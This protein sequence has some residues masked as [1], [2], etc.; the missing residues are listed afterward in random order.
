MMYAQQ[1]D[2]SHVPDHELFNPERIFWPGKEAENAAWKAEIERRREAKRLEQENITKERAAKRTAIKSTIPYGEPFASEI[3]ER[4]S[5]GE[6][7]LDICEDEHMPTMR[8]CNQWLKEHS[9]F[10]A[11]YKDSINDRLNIFEEQVIKIADDMNNDFKTVTKNGRERRVVDPDV[12]MRAKLRI[13]V[14]FKHLNALR[15]SIWGEQS[16]LITKSGDNLDLENMTAEELAKKIA[17]L[18]YKDAVVKAA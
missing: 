14:R 16:T 6:L 2:F 10:A 18:E 11:L 8:R 13:E 1:F 17:E 15:P 4:I 9:D 3:C 12:I 5:C 7:L